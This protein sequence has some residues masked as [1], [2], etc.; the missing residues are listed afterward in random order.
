MPSIRIASIR[1]SPLHDS[2]EQQFPWCLQ[3]EKD[4]TQLYRGY[5]ERK[6]KLALLDYDDLLL[7]WHM[8]MS[9]PELAK[10]VGANFDHVLVDEYQDTNSLQ[11]EDPRGH[12]A[13]WRR[14]HRGRR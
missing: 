6:Q 5:V 11:V 1:R 7:Y 12:E 9:E 10:Q 13:R 14:A 3:W 2:L 8:L 4:L